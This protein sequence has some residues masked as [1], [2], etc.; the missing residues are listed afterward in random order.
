MATHP[1]QQLPHVTCR[2]CDFKSPV[3]RQALDHAEASGHTLIVPEGFTTPGGST[4]P[5]GTVTVEELDLGRVERLAGFEHFA[6]GGPLRQLDTADAAAVQADAGDL[7][8][9]R[10]ANFEANPGLVRFV[11]WGESV[12]VTALPEHTLQEAADVA[13]VSSDNTGRPVGDWLAYT[14]AA[15]RL[16]VTILVRDMPAAIRAGVYLAPAFAAGSAPQLD[17]LPASPPAATLAAELETL[18]AL[19]DQELA[20]VA[21]AEALL[22]LTHKAPSTARRILSGLRTYTTA[23]RTSA[24]QLLA[25]VKGAN[26]G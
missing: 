7:V 8:A 11:L 12:P 9:P 5:P 25:E 22:P 13:L 21:R 26:H 1:Q 19:Y 6:S 14:R 18:I 10:L 3:Y 24:A 4:V 20:T 23:I 2:G 16:D 17:T 15:E